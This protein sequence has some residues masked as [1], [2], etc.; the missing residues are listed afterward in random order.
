MLSIQV[1]AAQLLK[2]AAESTERLE[3]AATASAEAELARAREEE[4]AEAREAERLAQRLEDM[5]V[6]AREAKEEAERE[7]A[8]Q[9]KQF[10]R[11]K[12]D[13]TKVGFMPLK[14]LLMDRG[15]PKEQVF[16][17]P[18]KFALQAVA[19]KWAEELKIEWVTDA[20]VEAT[21]TQPATAAAPKP[22]KRLSGGFNNVWSKQ[23]DANGRT[24]WRT[25]DDDAPSSEAPVDLS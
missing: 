6:K 20:P 23:P 16:G 12:A 2:K 22:A 5:K 7:A 25:G 13:I 19:Q 24:S 14:K 8:E 10:G 18:S 11:E 21:T 17:A 3:Q 9:A 1:N 4:E 15:V